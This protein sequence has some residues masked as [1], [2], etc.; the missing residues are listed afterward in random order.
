MKKNFLKLILLIISIITISLCLIVMI[1]TITMKKINQTSGKL[2]HLKATGH[3]HNVILRLTYRYKPTGS[4]TY[5]T[6]GSYDTVL[7]TCNQENFG[8]TMVPVNCHG[9]AGEYEFISH[10]TTSR[11]VS[12]ATLKI[13][14]ADA[15]YGERLL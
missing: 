7:G 2:N 3:S 13:T 9:I 8:N 1:N 12:G 5:T 11:T 14:K 4:T 15:S 10:Q 6:I